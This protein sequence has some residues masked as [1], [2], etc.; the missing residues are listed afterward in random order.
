M[1]QNSGQTAGGSICDHSRSFAADAD[2]ARWAAEELRA[3]G[4]EEARFEAQLL[5]A[6]A[7][8]VSRSSVVARTYAPLSG[9]QRERFTDLIA[10][11]VR[12]VPFAYLRGT[13]E[14][15]RR[16]FV[17]TPAVLVPRPETELLVEKVLEKV[18]A[19]FARDLPGQEQ[20][21][22]ADVGTGSGCIAVTLAAE[23][24]QICA[25]AFDISPDALALAQLNARN[26][27]VAEQVRFVRGDLLTGGAAGAFDIVASNPPYIPTDVIEGL[28]AEVRDYEPRLA[29]DGGND[30]LH[31]YRIL[32]VG[33]ER[34]L[35]PGGWLFMEVGQ[36]QADAVSALMRRAG[37]ANIEAFRDLAGIERVVCGQKR[38][39][40]SQAKQVNE[41][42]Q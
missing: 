19:S 5:L 41:P 2:W 25:V 24:A 22:L 23:Q 31:V 17:V 35:K 8:G 9:E 15:Y 4:V 26:N 18:G 10:R 13:Q 14:F 11:R 39:I 33:S 28:Q 20:V 7:L 27:G 16:E 32:V 42:K 37:Y 1:L 29:L 12:R 3:A 30:G 6:F 40:A 21:T 36:G 34:A 38:G